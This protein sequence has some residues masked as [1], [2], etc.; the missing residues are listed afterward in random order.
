M[1]LLILDWLFGL[2]RRAI[3]ALRTFHSCDIGQTT[4]AIALISLTGG[5]TLLASTSFASADEA[6]DALASTVRSSVDRVGASLEVRGSVIARS[7]DG[8]D[9]DRVELVLGVFGAG[10]VPLEG[11]GERLNVSY[12]DDATYLP[13]VPFSA[14]FIEGDGDELL[15]PGE[16]ALMSI[17]LTA[18]GAD[19]RDNERF[20]LELA[21]PVGGTVEISR[22]MPFVLQPVMSLH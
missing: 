12:R 21:G 8:R 10:A 20:T 15:E 11:D 22:T 13:S 6:F 19:L 17:D 3:W 14:T 2:V 4:T 9:T 18:A 16:M 1:L 5:A 7:S